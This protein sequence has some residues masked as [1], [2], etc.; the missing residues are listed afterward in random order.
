MATDSTAQTKPRAVITVGSTTVPSNA[1]PA[2]VAVAKFGDLVES[3]SSVA[4]AVGR[5][6]LR[7]PERFGVEIRH[8]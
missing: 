8:V 3:G 2:F 7:N 4:E 5:L 6:V 1:E